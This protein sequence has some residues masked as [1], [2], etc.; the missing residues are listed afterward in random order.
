MNAKNVVI[1]GVE[2]TPVVKHTGNRAVIVVDRGWIW[3]GD[4]TEDEGK[5]TLTNAVWIFRWEGI[6]F[7]GVLANPKSSKAMLKR[8]AN[9]VEIPCG[10][11]IFRVP[12]A[13]DWAL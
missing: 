3:A 11:I 7:D 9:S 13:E 8:I 12:V 5:I 1:D 4:V 2:Y 6:G 10:S